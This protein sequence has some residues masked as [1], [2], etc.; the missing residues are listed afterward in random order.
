MIKR[1]II[2]GGGIGGMAAALALYRGGIDVTV[3]ERAPAFSEMGA[4][5]SAA[6]WSDRPMGESL[7]RK[8]ARLGRGSRALTFGGPAAQRN[9]RL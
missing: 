6:H 2:A 7:D 8:R 4:G 5:S 1:L 3:L 9:L